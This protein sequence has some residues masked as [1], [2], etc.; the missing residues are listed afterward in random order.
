MKRKLLSLLLSVTMMLSM[1]LTVSAASFPDVSEGS[2][3]HDPVDYISE[4]GIMTG[5]ANG[6]F[7]PQD[8]LTR[9]QV[10]TTI[11]RMDGQPETVFEWMFSDVGDKSYY[12]L[13]ITWAAKSGVVS[14][15]ANGYFGPNDKITREQFVTM[16]YRYANSEGIDTSAYKDKNDFPDG[17]KV[18]KFADKAISWVLG[19]G[20]ISGDQGKI[21]PQG[22][23]TR[24][25]C[26]TI[27]SRYLQ[28]YKI[29]SPETNTPEANTPSDN[30]GSS[31]S[32][33]QTQDCNH[34]WTELTK[35]VHHDA[36]THIV[37]HD[38]VGHWEGWY[39]C[40]ACGEVNPSREHKLDH[41]ENG[42]SSAVTAKE[43][44]E[45]DIE[46]WDET[47][48]DEKARDEIVII[49]YKC[50]ICEAIK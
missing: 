41:I 32:E 30:S 7:G 17:G 47:V 40:L 2:W 39:E 36:V 44:Y 43:K 31:D 33:N 35:T 14:G 28:T 29:N 48:I 26:A 45:V 3:F 18:S 34:K 10:A 19:A 27:L 25:Q 21:N 13:P 22:Y 15:Y 1:A 6:N 16:L 20:I 8:Q 49:G 23:T 4:K 11:F 46:A 5:Y 37:H 38:E 24:A 9:G 12:S 50:S 42:V